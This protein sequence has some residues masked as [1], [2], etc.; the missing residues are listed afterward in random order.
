MLTPT[1]AAGYSFFD[2]GDIELLGRKARAPRYNVG[3]V[4]KLSEY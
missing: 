1:I 2:S 4:I 3:K